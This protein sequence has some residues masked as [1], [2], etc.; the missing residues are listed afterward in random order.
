MGRRFAATS[1]LTVTAAFCANA[2]AM[3]TNAAAA[4]TAARA[5][6]GARENKSRT[7]LFP[8]S[9]PATATGAGRA[10]DCGVSVKSDEASSAGP[11]VFICKAAATTLYVEIRIRAQRKTA[12]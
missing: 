7:F 10:A 6:K 1:T 2:G 3:G 8:A 11:C 9:G 12:A 4:E 5:E